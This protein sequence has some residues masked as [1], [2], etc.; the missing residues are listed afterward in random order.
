[1]LAMTACSGGSGSAG[2]D[3]LD[4]G[5]ITEVAYPSDEEW[6][7]MVWN[8]TPAQCERELTPLVLEAVDT[9]DGTGL[10]LTFGMQSPVYSAFDTAGR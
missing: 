8:S 6:A 2:V 1:M 9:H 3:S 4:G 7:E 5:D 10:M